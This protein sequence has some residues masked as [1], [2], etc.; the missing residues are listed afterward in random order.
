[1]TLASYDDSGE[2]YL[3]RGDEVKPNR[4]L[5]TGDVFLDVAVP[6][7][8]DG[9]L[10][11]VVAHPCS[12]RGAQGRLLERSL[13]S[14]VHSH[15]KVSRT[16]WPNGFYD[17]MPLPDLDEHGFCVALLD[18]LGSAATADLTA[19]VRVACLSEMGINMLQQRLTFHLTRAAIPTFQFHQAFAHTMI[20][21]DLLED[22]SDTL[23][24][25]GYSTAEATALFEDFI[26]HGDP[27]LQTRLL[28]P[29]LR[30][31]VRTAC[32]RQARL[33]AEDGET[34]GSS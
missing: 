10:V 4:P 3:T 23:T 26:R 16:S 2:L 11:I 17:R 24:D 25:A 29:E 28:D 12:L 8:Q 32:V 20:E 31:A 27:S 7:V 33:L 30:S 1:M 21:A 6:G 5:F 13:V 18:Q 22:W 14:V 19:S 34:H 15:D 9:G